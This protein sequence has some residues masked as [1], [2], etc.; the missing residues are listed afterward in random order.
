MKYI[1]QIALLV[2]LGIVTNSCCKEEPTPTAPCSSCPLPDGT[3]CPYSM[4]NIGGTCGCPED[5]INFGT[6]CVELEYNPAVENYYTELDCFCLEKFRFSFHDNGVWGGIIQ[7]NGRMAT[8]SASS[9]GAHF[10]GNKDNFVLTLSNLGSGP[11]GVPGYP[12][13]L[14][15]FPDNPINTIKIYGYVA[16]EVLYFDIYLNQGSTTVESCLGYAVPRF[17]D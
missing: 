1:T 4:L 3:Y 10:S 2:V 14:N 13:D 9:G 6:A 8:F 17:I 11:I 5:A 12:I 16:D 7:A 15:C